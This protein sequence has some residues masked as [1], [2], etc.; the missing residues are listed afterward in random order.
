MTLVFVHLYWSLLQCIGNQHIDGQCSKLVTSTS[1]S[2]PSV[3]LKEVFD[4]N[5]LRFASLFCTKYIADKDIIKKK[6]VV[7]LAIQLREAKLWQMGSNGGIWRR[8]STTAS[9]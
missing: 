2:Q 8:Y 9:G 4:T 7:C 5:N 6:D 3:G 1:L